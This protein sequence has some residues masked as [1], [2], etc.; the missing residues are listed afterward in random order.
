[1]GYGFIERVKT[2]TDGIRSAS[3]AWYAMAKPASTT[4]ATGP[5]ARFAEPYGAS[6]TPWPGASTT[7][8]DVYLDPAW[9]NGEGF[10]YSVAM[11]R[12]TTTPPQLPA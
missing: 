3:G 6:P 2:G 9:A 4:D 7:E 11:N 12:V 8:I 1:M 10:D 5:F